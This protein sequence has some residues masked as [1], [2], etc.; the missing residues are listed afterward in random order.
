MSKR[1]EAPVRFYPEQDGFWC[2]P[3][4][5][6]ARRPE[7][8]MLWCGLNDYSLSDSNGAPAPEEMFRQDLEIFDGVT[9]RLA[10]CSDRH[11]RRLCDEDIQLVAG[12]DQS[13][14]H[15][16]WRSV[17]A[18]AYWEAWRVAEGHAA[19]IRAIDTIDEIFNDLKPLE[20]KFFDSLEQGL[21]LLENVRWGEE[22]D[23]QIAWDDLQAGRRGAGWILGRMLEV[24]GRKLDRGSYPEIGRLFLATR[25]AEAF[26]L[27]TGTSPPFSRGPTDRDSTGWFGFL[28]ATERVLGLPNKASSQ[29]HDALM[30]AVA[31]IG[32]RKWRIEGLA[33]LSQ[34][35]MEADCDRGFIIGNLQSVGI[36]SDYKVPL[37][38]PRLRSAGR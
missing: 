18:R 31:D 33:K 20:R 36:L 19:E 15:M 1:A 22:S 32:E 8:V 11:I 27:C 12:L 29:G 16:R 38:D 35:G 26:A 2:F 3:K 30:R 21:E 25:L 24:S 5:R 17:V 7:H 10:L 37:K 6:T 34:S 14:A 28:S 4:F 13:E 23:Y 9:S